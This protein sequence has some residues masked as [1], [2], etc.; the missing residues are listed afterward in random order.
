MIQRR[1][2]TAIVMAHMAFVPAM[3][4]AQQAPVTPQ[5]TPVPPGPVLQLS[6]KQAEQMA[7][8]ANLGL[9]G[10]RINPDIA[11]ENL[12]AARGQFI[13]IVQSG[14]SR[15]AVTRATTSAFEGSSSS[16]TTKS[17]TAFGRVSQNLPWY[18]SSFQVQYGGGRT[19]STDQFAKFNPT[20]NSSLSINFQQPL[21]EGF[22]TDSN[23]TQVQT[24]ERGRQIADVQLEQSMV[25]TRVQ[26]Q[27]AYLNLTGAIE[28]LKVAQQN[29]ELARVSLRN[30][31][32]RV[33]VGTMAPIGIIQAEAEVA[34]NEEGVV[35]G[36][37]QV[38]TAEDA[39]RALIF[40][41][42]RP[43]Y[44]QVRIEPTDQIQ[45][46][47]IEVN[48]E[49][50]I[51]AALANR[52]DLIIAKRQIEVQDLGIRLLQ[53]QIK[54]TVDLVANYS[55]S[56]TGGTQNQFTN[57][58]PPVLKSSLERGL[59]TTLADVFK[60]SQPTW[61]VGLSGSYPIGKS[62]TEAALARNR[63]E[64]QRAEVQLRED[65]LQVAT[66]VRDAGRQVTTGA[67]RVQVTQL[68]REAAQKQLDAEQKKFDLGLSGI[69][70][71]QSRQ[72]DLANLKT[73]ELQAIIAYNRALIIFE[74]IQ[75][76]PVR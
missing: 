59:A 22:K 74:A 38:A 55:A 60:N 14:F 32:S 11:A 5:A 71:L 33:E 63:L 76:A 46:Q 28:S 18:G 19:E 58:F 7:F 29:L 8:E 13:P 20:L 50:A 34:S 41:P 27:N 65:E 73:R 51:A 30:N 12:A 66:T 54:P 70:E 48:V 72:R 64:K 2:V 21:L 1:A 9:K 16:L 26:V 45:S 62:P 15:G 52:T 56:G 36:E 17:L 4:F 31:K 24:A 10:D 3:A 53:N 6:M 69:F 57:D 25:L 68:A 61:S 47:P 37:G 43:D 35:L 75:K 67:K 23:R 39:L 42:A 44:W 49:A 40:D